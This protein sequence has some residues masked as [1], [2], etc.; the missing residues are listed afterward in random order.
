MGVS[1]LLS[2]VSMHGCGKYSG[3]LDSFGFRETGAR[4]FYTTQFTY[5]V[6]RN[7]LISFV[8]DEMDACLH[9]C[10]TKLPCANIECSYAIFVW[11]RQKIF[12]AYI[13]GFESRSEL[14]EV[15]LFRL[16][17]SF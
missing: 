5:N 7:F 1:S 10:A 16:S 6:L 17:Y 9:P 2:F 15:F 11:N 3:G 8:P 12:S 14:S 4:H 13:R